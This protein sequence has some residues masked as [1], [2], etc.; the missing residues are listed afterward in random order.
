M[1]E[2]SYQRSAEVDTSTVGERVILFERASK[3][4]IVLNP[5]GAQV[6]R[7]L[8]T[9]RSLAQMSAALQEQFPDVAASQ[10]GGDV[11]LY[12]RELLDQNLVVAA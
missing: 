2:V 12:L 5:T 10:I 1:T 3:R 11:E 8:E 6:W 4:A 9:P 7:L